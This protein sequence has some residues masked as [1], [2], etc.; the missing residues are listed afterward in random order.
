MVAVA[1]VNLHALIYDV[2]QHFG[3]EDLD[4]R[5]F[6]R[7]FL[8]RFQHNLRRAR[9]FPGKTLQFVLNQAHHAPTGALRRV[10][11]DGHFRQF[12]LDHSEFGDRLS[13]GLAFLGVLQRHA[14]HFLSA[15]DRERA[16]LQTAQIQNIESDDMPAP[17]LA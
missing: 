9:I 8:H 1:A 16:Q 13:E 5:A 14:Q 15:A 10:N 4:I 2:I 3:R 12:M 11:P 7:K 17:N 6:G